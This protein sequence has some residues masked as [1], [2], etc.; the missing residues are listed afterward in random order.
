MRLIL[1]PQ[2]PSKLRYQEWY[3]NEFPRH[4]SLYFDEIKVIG[5]DLISNQVFSDE[6][7]F[8]P[9][10]EA[11]KFELAQVDEYL[12]LEL[13]D[14]D[15]LLLNDISFPGFFTSVLYHKKPSKTFC[16]CHGTSK[17]RYD[18]FAKNR[19]S[20]W[21]VEK[22]YA[23]MFDG[24][25]LGSEYHKQKL[26]IQDTYITYLPKAPYKTFNL[27]KDIDIISVSRPTEQK[28]NLYLESEIEKI[29]NTKIFRKRYKTWE[30]YY[31]HISRSRVMLITSCEETF[32]YQVL[33]SVYNNCIPIAPNN[34]SYPELLPSE[35][36]YDDMHD[37]IDILSK[38]FEIENVLPVP[39]LLCQDSIDNFYHNIAKIM[40]ES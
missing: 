24:I 14:D 31:N 26:A 16:I 39:K 20:K 28:V 11:I 13:R 25:F 33:D 40:L 27:K 36:L 37:L 21:S 38:A 6:D 19:H 34:Y 29:F 22:G 9:I 2:F 12:D 5:D 23:E 10:N 17:N 15:I 4:L 32:G 8:S 35:Y 3:F 7:M 1:V 30:E 18:Y